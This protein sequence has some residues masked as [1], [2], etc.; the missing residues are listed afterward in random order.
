ME[1]GYKYEDK[2]GDFL[3]VYIIGEFIAFCINDG[4]EIYVPPEDVSKII[5]NIENVGREVEER[6]SK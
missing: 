3:E 6:I 1:N 5:K 2:D 4:D